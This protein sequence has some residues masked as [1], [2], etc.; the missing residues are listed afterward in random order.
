MLCVAKLQKCCI[1]MNSKKSYSVNDS[2][3]VLVQMHLAVLDAVAIEPVGGT[4]V[5]PSPRRAGIPVP[6]TLVEGAAGWGDRVQD[7]WRS[8]LEV[9]FCF[10]FRNQA[11]EKRK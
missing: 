5:L 1:M 10:A 4:R 6:P 9:L 3:S 2:I 11:S 8:E 7:P